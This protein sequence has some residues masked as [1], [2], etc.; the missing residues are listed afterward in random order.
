MKIAPRVVEPLLQAMRDLLVEYTRCV[1]CSGELIATLVAGKPA[2]VQT[3]V[4]AQTAAFSKME[5][6]ERRRRQAELALT[7]SLA[8]C[9][10]KGSPNGRLTITA[11]LTL[12]P[13]DE[14]AE[15]ARLRS[16]LLQ[17][18]VRLQA[19]QHHCGV[20]SRSAL[21]TVRRTCVPA[22]G[23]PMYGPHGEREMSGSRP[24]RQVWRS[25]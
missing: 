20:L 13:P 19:L 21:A 18:L 23:T 16:D 15:L 11:L 24:H 8:G 14:A 7:R 25:A 9:D 10:T 12:L 5:A 6:A 2:A 3:A 22:G 17:T 4:M 1:E